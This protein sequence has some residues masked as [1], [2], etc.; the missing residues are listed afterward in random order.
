MKMVSILLGGMI[1]A[2]VVIWSLMSFADGI[3]SSLGETR[4]ADPVSNY[5]KY[6]VSELARLPELARHTGAQ[7]TLVLN[8][9]YHIDV[10]KTDSL[11]SPLV[12]TCD[13]VVKYPVKSSQWRVYVEYYLK[14]SLTHGYQDGQWVMTAGNA[15]IIK[16]NTLQGG[17]RFGKE[18]S[19]W[20]GDNFELK[21]LKNIDRICFDIYVATNL[22]ASDS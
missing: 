9:E 13:I 11:V 22:V 18:V 10:R 8:N 6:V 1:V 16:V 7:N 17:Y 15:R 21:A 19:G 3:T 4:P 2:A 14:L 5:R 20:K 12:G